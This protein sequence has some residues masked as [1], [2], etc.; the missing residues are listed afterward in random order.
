MRFSSLPIERSVLRV[1][2]MRNNE[3]KAGIPSVS[4]W[5]WAGLLLAALSSIRALPGD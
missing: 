5:D 1:K 3:S 2:C 4:I